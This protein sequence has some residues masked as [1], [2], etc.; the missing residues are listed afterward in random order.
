M[1]IRDRCGCGAEFASN[2]LMAD[3]DHKRWLAAHDACRAAY[4]AKLEAALAKTHEYPM[5]TVLTEGGEDA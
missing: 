2:T 4:V 1:P 3:H 5:P